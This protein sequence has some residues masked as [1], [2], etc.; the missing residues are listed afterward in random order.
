MY[1]WDCVGL[2]ARKELQVV[3]S[4]CKIALEKVQTESQDFPPGC[5]QLTFICSDVTTGIFTL[6]PYM[7]LLI[8]CFWRR[9]L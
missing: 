7:S 4:E 1:G 8:L 9:T 6:H 5:S 2:Q 3:L